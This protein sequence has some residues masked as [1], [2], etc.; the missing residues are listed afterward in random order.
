M[1]SVQVVAVEPPVLAVLGAH[2]QPVRRS[3]AQ[4][5]F[6]HSEVAR[7]LLERQVGGIDRLHLSPRPQRRETAG[8]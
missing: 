1:V 2:D 3:L 5:G 7:S 4:G 8:C 6:G